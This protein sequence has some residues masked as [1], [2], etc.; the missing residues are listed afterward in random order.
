MHFVF[1]F[2]PN[3]AVFRFLLGG[4]S[5]AQMMV[6]S[7]IIRGRFRNSYENPEPFVPN[8][9]AEVKLPLQ[10]VCH[11]FKAGHRIMIHVQ[12]NLVSVDRSEPSEVRRQNFQGDRR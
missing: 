12:S 7:E 8:E 10:D 3:R 4:R 6:R 11:T 1:V 5:G 2:F 9:M